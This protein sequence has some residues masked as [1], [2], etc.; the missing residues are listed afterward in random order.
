[1][2]KLVLCAV[3]AAF[4]FSIQACNS[5]SQNDDGMNNSDSLYNNDN[6]NVP[7]ADTT[8]M[9]SMQDSI[10]STNQLDTIGRGL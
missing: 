7:P 9:G 6:M 4:A 10:D 3:I 8:G 5:T 2:K 1:M